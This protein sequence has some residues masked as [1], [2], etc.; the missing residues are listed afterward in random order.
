[1]GLDVITR[2]V[3]KLTVRERTKKA[4]TDP[5]KRLFKL[6]APIKVPVRPEFVDPFDTIFALDWPVFEPSAGAEESKCKNC[7]EYI[8]F[9][10]LAS[11]HCPPK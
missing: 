1:M 9:H 5:I 10:G 8:G 3:R 6:G 4:Y 11:N 7:G 2:R